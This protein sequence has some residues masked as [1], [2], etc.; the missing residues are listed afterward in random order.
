M[1][2]THP[3]AV[4]TETPSWKWQIQSYAC[5]LAAAMSSR[6]SAY[7]P[8]A[9]ATTRFQREMPSDESKSWAPVP[10]AMA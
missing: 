3:E 5:A 6:T 7:R 9:I 1:P 8:R 2:W 4:S 10:P